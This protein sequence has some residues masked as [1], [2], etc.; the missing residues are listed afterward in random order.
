MV[1]IAQRTSARDEIFFRHG[2]KQL[3]QL[4]M[5]AKISTAATVAAMNHIWPDNTSIRTRTR[6]YNTDYN[7][8]Q[9][10]HC[11]AQP[12]FYSLVPITHYVL[13]AVGLKIKRVCRQCASSVLLFFF[14]FFCAFSLL[15]SSC[16]HAYFDFDDRL[17]SINW[18]ASI[19]YTHYAYYTIRCLV[20]RLQAGARKPYTSNNVEKHAGDGDDGHTIFSLRA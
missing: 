19:I 14:F 1:A 17:P 7:P 9:M 10:K 16:R 12:Q 6:V 13:V 18:A 3:F 15:S 11:T 20:C 2:Q 4:C 5:H 8:V